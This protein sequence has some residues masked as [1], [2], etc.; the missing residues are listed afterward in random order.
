MGDAR[1][2]APLRAV[3]EAT[4]RVAVLRA[5]ADEDVISALAASTRAGDPS[6]ANV[7]ATEAHNR[8][9]R[10]RA[11]TDSMIEGVIVATREG[12][13]VYVNPAAERM[14]GLGFP[15][16]ERGEA[17]A[18]PH[19]SPEAHERY[20]HVLAAE[21]EE[22]GAARIE[23]EMRRADGT[24][25][26]TEQALTVLR[27]VAGEMVGWV[28]VL[29]DVTESRQMRERIAETNALHEAV[30]SSVP[31]L[32]LIVD[33][34]LRVVRANQAHLRHKGLAE[35]DVRGLPVTE[36][37]DLHPENEAAIRN[38]LATGLTFESVAE[39]DASGRLWDWGAVPLRDPE[40]VVGGLLIAL[41]DTTHRQ[42]VRKGFPRTPP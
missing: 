15:A 34:D 25:L 18:L 32:T 13:V 19:L 31:N 36:A 10:A 22:R 6:I 5:L 42:D 29:H 9:L 40:G 14:F 27:D 35:D 37:L 3:M 24:H 12:H 1:Y 38:A 16:F 20:Q 11:I 41:M 4:D 7:L 33:R 17:E 39:A 2:E 26:W 8:V 21:F 30:F 23:Y 28:L